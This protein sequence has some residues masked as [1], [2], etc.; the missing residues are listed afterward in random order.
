MEWA[1]LLESAVF[2]L[3]QGRFGFAKPVLPDVCCRWLSMTVVSMKDLW[4]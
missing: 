1:R 2:E 3:P 4:E